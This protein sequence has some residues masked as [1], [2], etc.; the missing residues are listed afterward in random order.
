MSN[1]RVEGMG[2]GKKK[3]ESIPYASDPKVFKNG[4]WW[5]QWCCDCNLRHIWRFTILRG[6]SPK[7]DKIIAHF[8]RD[9][10]PTDM[11]KCLIKN[12]LMSA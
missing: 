11:A 5:F 9:Q 1:K 2:N 12:K 7:E 8:T 3:L 10:E 6:K 4:E